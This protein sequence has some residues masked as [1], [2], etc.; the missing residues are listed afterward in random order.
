MKANKT[1]CFVGTVPTCFVNLDF[2]K[3]RWRIDSRCAFF[4]AFLRPSG[5]VPE[6]LFLFGFDPMAIKAI[7]LAARSS[8]D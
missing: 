4:Y 3:W 2:F 8:R 5:L 6:G 7:S 1:A